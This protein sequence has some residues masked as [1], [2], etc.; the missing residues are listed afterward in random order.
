MTI[1]KQNNDDRIGYRDH[2]ER[3]H[4]MNYEYY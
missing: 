2:L 1:H 3:V 4:M